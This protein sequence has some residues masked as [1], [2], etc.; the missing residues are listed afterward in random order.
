MV[1]F[2]ENCPAYFAENERADYADYLKN[3]ADHYKVAYL[4]QKLVAAFGIGFGTKESRARITWIMVSPDTHGKG[5][6]AKMM[7]YAKE[8]AAS[9]N[10]KTIDIAASHLSAP[11]FAKFGATTVKTT[12]HGWGPDMH[13]HD[14]EITL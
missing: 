5:I 13:R 7:D 4:G 3:K 10:V 2:D 8:Y 6:G 9:Q 1:L 12:E 11:F 14:M